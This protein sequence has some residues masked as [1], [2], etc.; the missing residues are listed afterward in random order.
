MSLAGLSGFA[1]SSLLDGALSRGLGGCS[2]GCSCGGSL[3]LG[4]KLLRPEL[5]H[6]VSQPQL[7]WH[8]RIS[9]LLPEAWTSQSRSH[10]IQGPQTWLTGLLH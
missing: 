6:R 9:S 10:I 8:I 1:D 7:Q 5:R 2:L 3:G 4:L